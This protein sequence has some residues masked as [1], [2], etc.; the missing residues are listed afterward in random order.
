MADQHPFYKYNGLWTRELQNLVR[1]PAPV[2]IDWLLIEKVTAIE[3]CA[4]LGGFQEYKSAD[5]SEFLTIEEV[6]KFLDGRLSPFFLLL[7]RMV[8]MCAMCSPREPER[9]GCFPPDYRGV[10]AFSDCHG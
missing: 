5:S 4:W 9:G 3:L 6:G 10:S 2:V 8:L 1:C 7:A